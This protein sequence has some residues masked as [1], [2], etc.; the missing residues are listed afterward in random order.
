MPPRKKQKTERSMS[1]QDALCPATSNGSVTKATIIAR[2]RKGH[3]Q[4]L[5]DIALEIQSE[6]YSYLGSKDLW[7]LS[8]TCKRFRTF[9]LDR[10]MNERLWKQA[11]VNT[12]GLPKCPPFMSEPSFIHLLFSSCCQRCGCSNV[13]KAIWRWFVRYCSKCLREMTYNYYEMQAY[14]EQRNIRYPFRD[15]FTRD[16]HRVLNVKSYSIGNLKSRIHNLVLR[17]HLTKIIDE[18]QARKAEIL[19]NVW[20]FVSEKET[21]NSKHIRYAM[22]CKAWYNAQEDVRLAKLDAAREAR[23]A[24]IVR[25]LRDSEWEK[26]IDFLGPAGLE[27]MSALPF[28]RQAAKL[29]PKAWQ[30]VLGLLEPVLQDAR[31]K[32]L[33]SERRNLLNNRFDA[34]GQ[35]IQAHYVRLPRTATMEFRP[36]YIDF[37]LM[38][39]F[40]LLL[41][42]PD[43]ENITAEDF[44][45]LIPA[46]VPKWETEQREKLSS[47]MKEVLP[48]PVAEGVDVLDL[49]VASLDTIELEPFHVPDPYLTRK[50]VKQACIV[51]EALGYEPLRTTVADLKG[52]DVRLRCLC[53]RYLPAEMAYTWETALG[54]AVRYADGPTHEK[55]ERIDGAAREL[56]SQLEAEVDAHPLSP[57]R[58]GYEAIIWCCSLCL[59]FDGRGVEMEDHLRTVHNLTDVAQCVRDKTIYEHPYKSVKHPVR[60]LETPAQAM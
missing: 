10:R 34:L 41:D 40:K 37:A 55:W 60:L 16:Y 4:T 23:F 21:L 49:A 20:A 46:V 19:K 27:S 7:N 44:S 11:R 31:Q 35:A 6:I 17:E 42:A 18:W 33:V 54:H 2:P 5:P 56:V 59:N 48:G 47:F 52:C 14:L 58:H 1:K 3:L 24:E 43:A 39:D 36:H 32:R 12:G 30:T 26:E 57:N 28:V 45:Q 22:Q 25:R 51:M 53:C 38:A 9:F 50:A 13:H 15:I 29:T 8:R